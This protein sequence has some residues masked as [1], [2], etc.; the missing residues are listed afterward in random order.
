MCSGRVLS[1]SSPRVT[2]EDLSAWRERLYRGEQL[3]AVVARRL[4]DEVERLREELAQARITFAGRAAQALRRR[5][6]DVGVFNHGGCPACRDA[7]ARA[8]LAKLEKIVRAGKDDV[9][10]RHPGRSGTG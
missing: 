1:V 7:E 5:L 9:S 4:M 6:E 8:F 2:P 10:R 3:D